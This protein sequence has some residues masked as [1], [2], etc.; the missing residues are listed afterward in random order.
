MG[1]KGGGE[2]MDVLVEF[3]VGL[4]GMVFSGVA[5]SMSYSGTESG[6]FILT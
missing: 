6:I 5:C 1:G 4:R 2:G 3:A